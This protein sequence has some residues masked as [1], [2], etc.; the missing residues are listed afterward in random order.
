[1]SA[2]RT[3]SK[4]KT[5]QQEELQ[6]QEVQLKALQRQARLVPFRAAL[7]ALQA[8]HAELDA[9]DGGGPSP[10]ATA[11]VTPSDLAPGDQAAAPREHSAKAPT[12][13]SAHAFA[14]K[15]V[16]ACMDSE[17]PHFAN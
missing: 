15:K 5:K 4:L 14:A 10:K 2:K 6:R 17:Y 13:S 8:A 1:M 12:F 16:G 11:P 7:E 9:L 3:L